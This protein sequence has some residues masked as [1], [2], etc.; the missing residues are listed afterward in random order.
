MEL[1]KTDPAMAIYLFLQFL[2][3][4]YNSDPLKNCHD[5]IYKFFGCLKSSGL[6][7]M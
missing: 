2:R 5:D 4:S 1:F 6:N 7:C 3:F